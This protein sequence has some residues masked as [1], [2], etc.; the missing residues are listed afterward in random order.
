M[1]IFD[2][3]KWQ[4]AADSLGNGVKNALGNLATYR[5]RTGADAGK[6][7]FND[8]GQQSQDMKSV[9]DKIMGRE[10][11]QYDLNGDALYQQLRQTYQKQGQL[12]AMNAIGNA[13]AL[14]GG[15]GNS[16][17][18]A[19]G[20]QAYQQS[21]ENLNQQIPDL[22]AMALQQYQTE[23]DRLLQQYQVADSDR[24]F[25]YQKYRD[26]MS[27]WRDN[28]NFEYQQERDRV[29]DSQWDSEMRESRR[30]F[31]ENMGFNRERAAAQDEQW[32]KQ[33]D[34]TQ[35]IDNRN[36]E[37]QQGRDAVADEQWNKTFERGVYEWDTQFAANE[38]QRKIE[39]ALAERYYGLEQDKFQET[40]R[41]N[42]VGIDQWNQ[43]FDY[44]KKRDAVSDDQFW[45]E[46][47]QTERFHNDDQNYKYAGLAQE[48]SHFKAT[49]NQEDAQFWATM[50]QQDRYHQDDETYRYKALLQDNTQFYASLNQD[51]KHFVKE[52]KYK[53]DALKQDNTQFYASLNQNERQF[54]KDLNYKYAALSLKGG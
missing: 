4:Q 22:Y 51:E 50:N 31:D 7:V 26:D 30:Q 20:Q 10:A 23:G 29:A 47:G 25:Q 19:A 13:A 45:A 54:L 17:A 12:G 39:N 35:F 18:A 53:Y 37:Y 6:P 8:P 41:M 16:Y 28:R 42:Q 44:Q 46:Y 9:Y 52:L 1:G 34:Y 3:N 48:D 40:Q 2:K 32:Q 38:D 15:Y 33:F 5:E 36:F 24:A 21:L 49:M 14:S 43:T 11:F 27:D